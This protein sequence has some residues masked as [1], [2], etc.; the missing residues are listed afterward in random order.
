VIL[1]KGVI[2]VKNLF[3]LSLFLLLCSCEEKTKTL[4][5]VDVDTPDVEVCSVD[6]SHDVSPVAV[7]AD[8]T[9]D[10]E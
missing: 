2:I 1:T 4:D 9:G 8:A 10:K 5:V 6:A 7:A 3:T